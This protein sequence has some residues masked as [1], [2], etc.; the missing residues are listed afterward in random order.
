MLSQ[1][2]FELPLRFLPGL[3]SGEVIRYGT[4][5]K[6]AGTGRILGHLQESGFAQSLLSQTLTSSLSPLSLVSPIVDTASSVHTA[7]QVHQLKAMVETLQSLQL[8]TLGASLA[9]VGVSVAGFLYM[10]QRFNSLDRRI[11]QVVDT[12]KAGFE[13]QKRSD[14]RQHMSRTKALVQRAELAKSM[15]DPAKEYK[16]VAAQLAD[17]AAFFEGEVTFQMSVK[18]PIRHEMFWLLSQLWILCNSVRLDAQIRA[19]ELLHAQRL[20]ER[21]A[22]EYQNLFDRVGPA[23]FDVGIQEG[24]ATT[25]VLRDATDSASSKPFL[26]DHIRTRRIP[27][28]IYIERLEGEQEAPILLLQAR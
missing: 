19:N 22:G 21:I 23:S 3:A 16:D 17:Q 7:V 6:D 2:P 15:T 18:G 13:E 9:G 1:I 8:A 28:P 27:G 26:L 5:L 4:I 10:R 20:S 14:L 25:K 24:Q 12:V 11:D